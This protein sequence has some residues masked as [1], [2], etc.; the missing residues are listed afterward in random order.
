MSEELSR[1]MQSLILAAVDASVD[2][3]Y[4]RLKENSLVEINTQLNSFEERLDNIEQG[5]VDI[6]HHLGIEDG[7]NPPD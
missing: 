7:Y 6:K 2:A 4:L 3:A 1:E 5:I